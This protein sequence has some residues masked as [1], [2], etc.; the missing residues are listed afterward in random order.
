MVA[1]PN[2]RLIAASPAEPFAVGIKAASCPVH[3]PGSTRNTRQSHAAAHARRPLVNDLCDEFVRNIQVMASNES[4]CSGAKKDDVASTDE[5]QLTPH[6]A[7]ESKGFLK[8]LSTVA[9]SLAGCNG[10]E[11]P[12]HRLNNMHAGRLIHATRVR[13]NSESKKVRI[14]IDPACVG[15]VH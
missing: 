1:S 5:N 6:A 3:T 12:R 4:A 10:A 14:C 8:K 11:A 15:R 2:Y 7:I 13:V 9:Q